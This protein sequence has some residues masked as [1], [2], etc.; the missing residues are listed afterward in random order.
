M[1]TAFAQLPAPLGVQDLAAGPALQRRR[2]GLGGGPAVVLRRRLA[3][4]RAPFCT[5]ALQRQ[6]PVFEPELHLQPAQCRARRAAC[7]RVDGPAHLFR[8]RAGHQRPARCRRGSGRHRRNHLRQAR[9]LQPGTELRPH[10]ERRHLREREPRNEGRYF[11]GFAPTCAVP[12]S[13]TTPV[14]VA[15]DPLLAAASEAAD[16]GFCPLSSQSAQAQ[17]APSWP[18]APHAGAASACSTKATAARMI[19]R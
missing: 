7:L 3:G 12:E 6:A 16:T 18:H 5:P 1:S 13:F 4:R 11:D 9:G 10:L 14:G 17:R 2:P 19:D 15:G 8:E